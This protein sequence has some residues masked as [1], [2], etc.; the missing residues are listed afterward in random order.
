MSSVS[1][2]F[3][4]RTLL[5]VL[6][7]ACWSRRGGGRLVDIMLGDHG[8]RDDHEDEDDDD[9]VNK[10]KITRNLRLVAGLAPASFAEVET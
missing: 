2:A 10:L 3:S 8:D 6:T 9:F 1:V 4:L 5:V 7:G